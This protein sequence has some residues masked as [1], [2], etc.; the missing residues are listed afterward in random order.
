MELSREEIYREWLAIK[1]PGPSHYSLL[2]LPELELDPQVIQHAGRRVKR[3]LRAYQIGPY[4]KQALDLLAEVG[5]AVAV[6]TSEEKRAAYDRDLRGRWK[7]AAEELY[8]AHCDGASPGAPVLETWLGACV[9]RGVPVTRILP[10]ILRRMGAT[11]KGWPPHGDHQL[12]L[13]VGLWLYR[14][15][16]ILGQCL[17]IGTLER[18]AEA[19]KHIQKTL[20]V[21]EGLARLVAEEVSRSLHLFARS[22]FVA[23]AKRDPEAYLVRLGRRVHR[24]GGHLGRRAEVL[25][26]VAGLLGVPRKGL[27]RVFEQV[28]EPAARVSAARKAARASRWATGEAKGAVQWFRSRPQVAVVVLALG[29]GMAVLLLA[30]LVAGGVWNP[31]KGE[32]DVTAPPLAPRENTGG[33]TH[34]GSPPGEAPS[35][36]PPVRGAK[37][38]VARPAEGP[39]PPVAAP[40]EEELQSLEGFIKK[41]PSGKA[42][43]PVEGDT[44]PTPGGKSLPRRPGGKTPT[45]FSV[46]A[47]RA[48]DKTPPKAPET[49]APQ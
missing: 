21:T 46:P 47:E 36:S 12:A 20:G 29:V 28:A 24:Y 2:G 26:T 22:R 25:V 23:Q 13:P 5:Q 16:V 35:L 49:P 43:A 44:P 6:L 34:T 38:G 31:W 3:K 15:A 40:T 42:P 27:E 9:A 33:R 37:E 48:P 11:L 19:V 8:R 39:L 30:V 18:R 4:R 45:F 10:A 14:D 41:Y 1:C 17:H 32:A 7:S